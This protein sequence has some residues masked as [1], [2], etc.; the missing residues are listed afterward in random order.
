M[1][2]LLFCVTRQVSNMGARAKTINLLLYDGSLQG[3]VSIED[4]GWYSGEMYS[5]P[6]EAVEELLATEA[7][8]KYGVYLLLS[9]NRVYVGQSSDLSRRIAEHLSTK[10]WWESVVILT[11]KDDSLNHSDIDWLETS[12][13][14]K[15]RFI[16]RLDCDNKQKG[17]P[18]KAD[19]Y[20]EVPLSQYLEEALFLMEFIGIPV[21]SKK[22]IDKDRSN[23]RRAM[24]VDV[25]DVHSR[26]AFGKRSKS[27][28]IEYATENGATVWQNRSYAVLSKNGSE[29]FLNPVRIMLECDWSIVLNDTSQFELLILNVPAGTLCMSGE[30]RQGL[31]V[32]KD[33]PNYIDLHLEAEILKDRK[34]G[35]DFSRFVVARV[36]Y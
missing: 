9:R 5:A 11:T 30:G 18:V 2:D 6:R 21:F 25:T 33:K 3:V 22:A 34:S 13:I 16:G 32:R 15:A 8:D 23:V 19:K 31:L 1:S 4:S 29:F 20:S 7:C 27:L 36:G 14:E 17:N 35:I 10:D 24:H 28:A 26:L 12:L